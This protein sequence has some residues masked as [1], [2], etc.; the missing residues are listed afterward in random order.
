MEAVELT[1]RI[2]EDLRLDAPAASTPAGFITFGLGDNLDDAAEGAIAG[3][4]DHL[5]RSLG[6]SR[7]QAAAL[8]G[9]IV[10]L[11][12]TQVVNGTVGVHAILP[13]DSLAGG[14]PMDAA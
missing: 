5:T 6:V 4:L 3:M 11:R 12:I 14:V 7:P 9:L 2:R 13:R 8:S 1:F 10:H